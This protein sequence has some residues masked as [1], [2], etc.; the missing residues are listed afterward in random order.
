[1]YSSQTFLY[2]EIFK[3]RVLPLVHVSSVHTHVHVFIVFQDIAS[4]RLIVQVSI[5]Y[6]TGE[7]RGMASCVLCER[8][9]S[10]EYF[11]VSG[12]KTNSVN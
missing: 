1:M 4:E 5:L 6:R 7:P 11:G 10:E 8:F 9:H 2:E 12:F 3:P